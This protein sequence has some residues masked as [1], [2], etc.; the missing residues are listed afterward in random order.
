[1]IVSTANDLRYKIC[2]NEHINE[3]TKTFG[4]TITNCNYNIIIV[5]YCSKSKLMRKYIYIHIY[6]YI[7]TNYA[8]NPRFQESSVAE[9]ESHA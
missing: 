3:P 7:Y 9:I 4:F 8:I 2:E 5:V 1:M 6:I